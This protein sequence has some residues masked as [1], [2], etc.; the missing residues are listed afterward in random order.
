M[1]KRR[2][3]LGLLVTIGTAAL[4]TAC[5][6]PPLTP[7]KSTLL[8][9]TNETIVVTGRTTDGDRTTGPPH[10]YRDDNPWS[11]SDGLAIAVSM[12]L[13]FERLL[14]VS[15]AYLGDNASEPSK[16]DTDDNVTSTFVVTSPTPCRILLTS[17][18]W[19]YLEIL[20][21]ARYTINAKVEKL[22]PSPGGTRP[23]WRLIGAITKQYRF[24]QVAGDPTKLDVRTGPRGSA[25]IAQIGNGS[26]WSPRPD[27]SAQPFL[28][29]LLPGQRPGKYRITLSLKTHA[30]IDERAFRYSTD[31]TEAPQG[32]QFPP[33]D[34]TGRSRK[35]NIVANVHVALR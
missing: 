21:A 23:G 33:P 16:S 28:L 22:I 4:L 6:T 26:L 18:A 31:G 19:V 12:P 5:Q 20:G 29:D 13:N 9:G 8:T 35:A 24:T 7:G 2:D 27:Q 11:A 15:G 10:S 1:N 14:G 25:P 34:L 30:D 3:L 17:G 32:E